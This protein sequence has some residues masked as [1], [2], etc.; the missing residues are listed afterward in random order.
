MGRLSHL[1][2]LSVI[3][4]LFFDGGS[5]PS[6]PPPVCLLVLLGAGPELS[7]KFVFNLEWK[8]GRAIERATELWWKERE[9]KKKSAGQK[10][11][12]R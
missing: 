7:F 2:V 10:R 6:S 1:P 8:G 9:E 12:D 5:L 3:I 11:G 4:P